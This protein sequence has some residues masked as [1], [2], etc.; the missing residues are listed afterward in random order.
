MS[1]RTIRY[2]TTDHVGWL[3]LN[4]PPAAL[5]AYTTVMCD[6]IVDVLT[7]YQADDHT[8]VLVL[9][10]EG[11]AFCAGGDVRNTDEV[12]EAHRRQLGHAW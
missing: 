1:Y 11:R 6:E 5:N 4:R 12:D 7:R 2:E 3:T 10:G 8:R 9:T